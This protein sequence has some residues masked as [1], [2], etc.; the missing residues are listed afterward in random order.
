MRPN[1]VT[2]R[3][4]RSS[5]PRIPRRGCRARPSFSDGRPPR[6]NVCNP[7]WDR[8]HPTPRPTCA[9]PMAPA[10]IMHG[11][12]VTYNVHPCRYLPPR[13]DAA[14]VRACISAWAV[15]SESVSTRLWPR[16]TTAPSATTTA[17][18]G[19]S[20]SFNALR[21]SFSARRMNFSSVFRCSSI[22]GIFRKNRQ[23]FT[24]G[25]VGRRIIPRR[26]RRGTPRAK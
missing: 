21:A 8:R 9:Q 3:K 20:C 7:S 19:T 10:H 25:L 12:T 5:M 24:N 22:S 23:T 13:V 16:P 14:A 11:S 1:R 26:S 6:N 4:K 2:R 18:I 17:P 15:G